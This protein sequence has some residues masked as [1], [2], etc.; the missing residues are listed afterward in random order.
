MGIQELKSEQFFRLY[1]AAQKR[2]YAYLLMLVHNQNDADDLFQ[3]TASVLWERF[4]EFDKTGSFAAWGIGIARNKA[5]D[6]LKSKQTSRPLFDDSFYRDI[7]E[8]AA[9]QTA[10]TDRRLKAL[11]D[12]SKKMSVQNQRLIHLRFEQGVTVKKI[13]QISE[14]SADAIYKRLSRIYTALHDCIDRTMLQWERT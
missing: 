10:E 3:E 14:F 1:N 12:C 5:F 7:S 11:Q 8:I 4:D 9:A 2:V 13:S 6:F